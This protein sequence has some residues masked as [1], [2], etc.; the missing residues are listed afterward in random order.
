MHRTVLKALSL[1]LLVP[2][3]FILI[4]G[5]PALA[6]SA[7]NT[8]ASYTYTFTNYCSYPVW[9][10]QRSATDGASYPPESG[11]WALSAI[12]AKNSDCASG[13]CD[14]ST[15]QCTCAISSQCSGGAACLSGKCSISAQFLMPKNW[16]SG[17]FWP[18]TGCT[19]NSAVTPARLTCK[20]GGCYDTTN[21]VN[22]LLD[23]SVNNHG[24]SPTNPVTQ[25]EVTSTASALN[26]DVSIAAGFNVET[27][28]EPVGGGWIV[29]GT[30]ATNVAAC[31]SAGCT[32]DLNSTCPANLRVFDPAD[33][34]KVIGCLDPCTQCERGSTSLNCSTQFSGESYTGCDAIPVNNV[35]Y[36]DMYCAKNMVDGN[37]QASSNQ[38]TPTAFGASDCFHGTTFVQPTF[39]SGY[40]LPAGQ[41]VCLYTTQPQIDIPHFNDYGWFDAAAATTKNC[42][43]LQA[44][45]YTAL[46]DGTPC[47][48]YLTPQSDGSTGYPEALGYTCQTAT[49]TDFS[50]N[51]QT[52]HLC[53]P[54]TN[55]GLGMCVK[56]NSGNKPLYNAVGGIT[57]ASWL[58]AGIAAGSGGVPYYSTFK[59]ACPT[60]YTWQYDDLSSGFGCNPTL[61]VTNGNT[62]SGFNVTFCKS[63][64]PTPSLYTLTVN[65][66][67]TGSGTVTGAGTYNYGAT[68][69]VTATAA[70]GSKFSAWSGACSG[71]Q[72]STTVLINGA[73]ICTATFTRYYNITAKAKG[74]G[75]GSVVSAPAGIKFVYPKKKTDSGSY[76]K[77]KTVKISAK[78]SSGHKATWN[79]SC[80]KAGGKESG[81]NTRTAVCTI[82]VA[83][84]AAVTAIFT[85]PHH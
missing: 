77:G 82:K 34:T 8:A 2:V 31:L 72:S 42:G 56:N 49:Y 51:V 73:K 12:C 84:A 41:G 59:A 62:F 17:T 40:A 37:A 4:S 7:C 32:A 67:G 20:T 9:I 52:A 70:T 68:A 14:I 45:S 1:F 27:Y 76:A 46:P 54:P 60:A 36:R 11:N 53:M 16:D 10:G 44:D 57:N 43:G 63:A 26:Y 66:T 50:S 6:W 33:S 61:Q 58:T 47:G 30:P 29:P 18:R 85:K 69:T 15:G 79:K 22:Q 28:A 75:A 24:G 80:A 64:T 39:A 23:C 5:L 71:T 38:G 13:A 83:K 55:S 3:L 25:F 78:A 81:D 19:L 48:G 21:S 74:T 65:K 35:T